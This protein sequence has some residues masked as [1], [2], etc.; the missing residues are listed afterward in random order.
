MA[1]RIGIREFKNRATEIIRRVRAGREYV[2]TVNGEPAAI[3]KPVDERP[4]RT[5][6]EIQ[7]DLRRIDEMV[8]RAKA[9]PQAAL[10][11]PERLR[12]ERDA[13]ERALHGE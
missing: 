11:L 8:E 7:R 9:W 4:R 5:S 13:R 10:S 12:A 3:V 6:E 2:I 1:E